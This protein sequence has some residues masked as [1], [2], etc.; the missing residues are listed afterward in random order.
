M[1]RPALLM[2]SSMLA[3]QKKACLYVFFFVPKLFFLF[4]WM[5]DSF[6]VVFKSLCPKLSEI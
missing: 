3:M 4:Q 2:K 5:L 1:K 6:S